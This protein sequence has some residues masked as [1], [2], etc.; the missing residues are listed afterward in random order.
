MQFDNRILLIP[1]PKE[2]EQQRRRRDQRQ[3]QN[4]VR[5][6]PIFTLALVQDDL[7]SSQSD[8]HEAEAYV[9]DFQL[10]K[11]PAAEVGRILNQARSQQ[12]RDDADR[13]VDEENPAPGVV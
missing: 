12:Q 1:L 4:E 10:G 6:E 7:Q 8:S 2:H 5:F 11:L 3:G 9:V 13:D